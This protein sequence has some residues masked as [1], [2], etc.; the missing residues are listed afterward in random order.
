[1]A[2]FGYNA[3]KIRMFK[4]SYISQILRVVA[5]DNALQTK[6]TIKKATRTALVNV[7]WVSL[8]K[9]KHYF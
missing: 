5:F 4:L 8:D 9:C 2:A 3:L 7:I 6:S 1:M